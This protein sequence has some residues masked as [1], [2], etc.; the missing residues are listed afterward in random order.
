MKYHS[1]F[2]LQELFSRNI[3]FFTIQ[4]NLKVINIITPTGALSKEREVLHLMSD[5][6]AAR[7]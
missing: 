2:Q 4:L 6:K 3:V 7:V 1:V 5:L